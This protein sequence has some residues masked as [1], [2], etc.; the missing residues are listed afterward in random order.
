MIRSH[1]QYSR[2]GPIFRP[3]LKTIL[4]QTNNFNYNRTNRPTTREPS[5]QEFQD[6]TFNTGPYVNLMSG[7][8]ATTQQGQGIYYQRKQTFDEDIR[9][10]IL[11]RRFG[12]DSIPFQGQGMH[13]TV[14]PLFEKGY[15]KDTSAP[16]EVKEDKQ[17]GDGYKLLPTD[18]LKIKVLKK[19]VKDR[20][21]KEKKGLGK[22]GMTRVIKGSIDKYIPKQSNTLKKKVIK[23]LLK[24]LAGLDVDEIKRKL[25]VLWRPIIEKLR[26]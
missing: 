12:R 17:Q 20:E 9:Q 19:I 21:K 7:S 3:S 5:F 6:K 26:S 23:F 25:P 18:K 4:E 2:G 10:Q 8:L 11:N 22:E 24:N 16:E 1:F 13:T 15:T 14:P